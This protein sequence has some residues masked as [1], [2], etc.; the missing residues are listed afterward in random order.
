MQGWAS[1]ALLG[2]GHRIL[3]YVTSALVFLVH[4]ACLTGNFVS[5]KVF[6]VFSVNS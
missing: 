1:P 4:N 6:V 3:W 2:A 5:L